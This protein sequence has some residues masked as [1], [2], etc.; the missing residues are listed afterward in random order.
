[1]TLNFIYLEKNKVNLKNF[2]KNDNLTNFI[3]FLT[4][5]L[6]ISYLLNKNYEAIIF[7]FFCGTFLLL[8]FKNLI[9]SLISSIILT[10]LFISL[11]YFK[12]ADI[13]GF[14]IKNKSKSEL[15]NMVHESKTQVIKSINKGINAIKYSKN[16]R[17]S[18]Y[19][20]EE[21]KSLERLHKH[22]HTYYKKRDSDKLGKE[23]L[24]HSYTFLIQYKDIIFDYI[25]LIKSAYSNDQSGYDKNAERIYINTKKDTKNVTREYKQY[26][27]IISR[28]NSLEKRNA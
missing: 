20:D 11:K 27:E 6:C 26:R 15:I 28:L 1:M 21:L 5:I 4:V 17:L 10:N 24:I 7:L 3:I 22:F 19:S 13:E 16:K 8:L 18:K 9:I 2:Y 25:D 14:S 12:I 23:N